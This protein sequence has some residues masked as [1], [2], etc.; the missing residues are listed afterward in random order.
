MGREEAHEFGRVFQPSD[1][2]FHCQPSFK[3]NRHTHTH[4]HTHTYTHTHT[5]THW[6]EGES[7]HVKKAETTQRSVRA[8]QVQAVDEACDRRLFLRLTTL[9]PAGQVKGYPPRSL[10]ISPGSFE[11][12]GGCISY[13]TV[14]ALGTAGWYKAPRNDAACKWVPEMYGSC[15]HLSR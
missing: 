6:Y 7:S 8:T 3:K 9:P 5:H 10:L 1:L 14:G 2:N 4:T 13:L 12:H 11:P 15:S